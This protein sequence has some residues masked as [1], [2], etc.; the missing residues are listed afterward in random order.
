LFDLIKNLKIFGS[1]QRSLKAQKNILLMFLIQFFNLFLTLELVPVTLNCIS[2]AEYGIWLTI[3]SIT[4]WFIN[5]DL[6]L[7]NG[8]R[9]KLTEA[10]TFKNNELARTYVS[11]TYFF[12]FI[13]SLIFFLVFAAIHPFVSWQKIFN[14][15]QVDSGIIN[16]VIFVV[17][18]FYILNF[19]L[20]LI[21]VI[22]TSYQMPVINSAYNLFTNLLTLV[23]IY[24]LSTGKLSSLFSVSLVYSAVPSV[25]FLAGSI[26]L[27]AKYFREV[28]PSFKY[29]KIKYAKDLVTLGFK[30]FI[31][32][33][34]FLI[35][36]ASDNLIIT[37]IFTPGDVTTYN[38]VLKYFNIMPVVFAVILTP[39]WSAFTEA[40][41]QKDIHWIRSNTKQLIKI[42]FIFTLIVI[43]MIIISGSVFKIWI[44][45]DF[46]PSLILVISMAIFAVITMWNNIFAYFLNGIGKIRIELLVAT[47][48]GIIN[49]PLSIIF[50]KYMN[51]GL[52]G[53]ILATSVCLLFGSVIT[54]I[55]YFKII[56]G[57]ASGIWL[58]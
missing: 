34:T 28:S 19:I 9:N 14:A 40:Y 20:K 23:I 58:K 1:S 21:G 46:T 8:L 42:W 22:V 55:Q 11:T 24:F 29:V 35:V 49:I 12:I 31:L 37:Q 53:V 15:P 38:I 33:I 44:G 25:V 32:Q 3:S 39:F 45:K 7:G 54:P 43:I 17:F 57:K 36:F 30:F 2:P 48:I 26:F 52:S 51:L 50:A 5:L 6:G 27:F 16:T 47:F 10:L 56:R 13:L 41:Q 4:I 18:S